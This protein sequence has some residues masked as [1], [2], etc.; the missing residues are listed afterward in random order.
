MDEEVVVR[1][2]IELEEKDLGVG[3]ISYKHLNTPESMV[4]RTS[5][6]SVLARVGITLLETLNFACCG[7]IRSAVYEYGTGITVHSRLMSRHSKIRSFIAFP[8]VCTLQKMD[9]PSFSP[10]SLNKTLRNGD[11]FV[12]LKAL[13]D[14]QVDI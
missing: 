13:W 2:Y 14:T 4:P 10:T 9:C 8:S 12:G 11:G 3:E 6:G 7:N 5:P 1:R